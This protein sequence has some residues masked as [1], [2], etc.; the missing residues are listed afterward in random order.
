M[1]LM[2]TAII[3]II[4]IITTTKSSNNLEVNSKTYEFTKD[5]IY[6][7]MVKVKKVKLSV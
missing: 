3:I 5:K 4:I 1:M 6:I 2:M 7:I